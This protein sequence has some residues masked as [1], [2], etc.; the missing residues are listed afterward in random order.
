MKRFLSIATIMLGFAGLSACKDEKQAQE[1][2]QEQKKDSPAS[3][4][5]AK[6]DAYRPLKQEEW[7]AQNV[8]CYGDKIRLVLTDAKLIMDPDRSGGMFDIQNSVPKVPLAVPTRYLTSRFFWE[9]GDKEPYGMR[10]NEPL[11]PKEFW[12]ADTK[13]KC[14]EEPIRV[15]AVRF[16]DG[17]GMGDYT[18]FEAMQKDGYFTEYPKEADLKFQI[19]FNSDV[20]QK[21]LSP[22]S[23]DE[24]PLERIWKLRKFRLEI[25]GNMQILESH[26]GREQASVFIEDKSGR[27]FSLK[28]TIPDEK[29]KELHEELMRFAIDMVD[30]TYL[31]EW[32]EKYWG[33]KQ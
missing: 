8:K 32:K 14:L 31:Q 19:R 12:P 18:A 16:S 25:L 28:G 15:G 13:P 17:Y 26:S 21:S 10:L 11:K 3:A 33:D 24:S 30:P 1:S 5:I 6:P 27:K 20:I 4:Q 23:I 2:K 9:P 22:V 29:L 7:Y